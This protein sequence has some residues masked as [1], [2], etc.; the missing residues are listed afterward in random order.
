MVELRVKTFSKELI[1][2]IKH[3]K[4]HVISHYDTDGITSAAIIS[5]TLKRLS[6]QFSLKIVKQL[7]EKEIAL[8]PKNKLI[9][10]TDLGSGYLKELSKKEN[11]IF[12]I[13][14]HEIK[15]KKFEAKNLNILNT[16]LLKNY[17]NLCAS[18]LSYLVSKEISEENKDLAKLAIIGL[19]GDSLGEEINK[20]RN[21][22]LKDAEVIVRKGFLI[23]PS[24]R[25]LDKA[26]EY[27]PRPFIP[28][29]SGNSKGTYELLKESGISRIG[30]HYKSLI[31]LTE[32]EM[33][34]LMTSIMLRV[35]TKE[36]TSK[37]LGNLYLIKFFNKIEDARELSAIINAC[38]RMGY[39]EVALMLCL[40][41]LTARKKAERIYFKYRQKI[42]SG[43]KYIDKLEKSNKI[44]GKNYVII[45]AKDKINDSLIG[46][47]MSILSF[48]SIYA[49][50]TI[51]IGMAQD[52]ENE[53]K[54]K[55]SARISGREKSE[56]N[57]KKLLEEVTEE[58]SGE[59]V[60]GHKVA[61]GALINKNQEKQ[62]IDS[63]KRKLKFDLIK[64][65]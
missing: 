15:N 57:L 58:I 25:P 45:N 22:I 47:L 21:D 20:I 56:R 19:I 13:D 65:P 18:E 63:I 34:A 33:K 10:L 36:K 30:N 39:S 27:N 42:V 6:K 43:L 51:L 40:K 23:Y 5:E 37:F 31:E 11:E 35:S 26:L 44:I 4:I 8:I 62:F 2:K 55:I 29:V 61:A 48:S 12:I 54:I 49:P 14:H 50:G 1:K 60:G 32:K 46:I 41:N 59:N 7:N 28:G 3:E 38:G 17:E 53:N 24:T 52:S 9:I 64:I 16:H